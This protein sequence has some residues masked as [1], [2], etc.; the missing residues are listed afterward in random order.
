MLVSS[1]TMTSD[2]FAE[3]QTLMHRQS[4]PMLKMFMPEIKL[5][6]NQKS[7]IKE[8]LTDPPSVATMDAEEL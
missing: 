8:I 6:R 2:E 3:L 4:R 7:I 1:D 5:H